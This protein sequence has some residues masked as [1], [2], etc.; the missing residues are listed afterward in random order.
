MIYSELKNYL[1]QVTSTEKVAL[2]DR[3]I[4]VLDIF[5]DDEYMNI[6]DSNIGENEGL[7]NDAVVD[8]VFDVAKL[9]LESL[10]Q[11]RGIVLVED[12]TLSDKIDML[13]GISRLLNWE[14]KD[15]L[16]MIVENDGSPVEKF[17]ELIAV[18][19]N[20]SIDHVL[21]KIED[22][23]DD[24]VRRFKEDYLDAKQNELVAP[25]ENFQNI[26]DYKKIKR[27][28]GDAPNWADHI[29]RSP[30]S[31][32]VPF[33][34]YLRMYLLENARYFT[35]ELS[36]TLIKV[37]AVDLLYL[38]ALSEEG[39]AHASKTIRA[40][41]SEIMTDINNATKLDIAISQLVVEVN[42]A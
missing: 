17:S 26:E 2:M 6:F 31:I 39:L 13:V 11:S 1:T 12:A 34:L 19:N 32:G 23:N 40:H 35:S 27:A 25:D 10:L 28:F 24:L 37:L 3:V 41:M 8:N 9:L 16:L 22:F 14:D 15:T 4:E 29:L 42:R 7:G 20:S 36:P 30:G 38:C 21:S 33:S 5:A 18:V